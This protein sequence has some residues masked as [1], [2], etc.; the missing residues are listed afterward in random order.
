ME[1]QGR[2][3]VSGYFRPHTLIPRANEA[4]PL[5][6]KSFVWPETEFALI[7]PDKKNN[8]MV[9]IFHGLS[10]RS[11]V[12]FAVVFQPGSGEETEQLIYHVSAKLMSSTEC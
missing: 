8:L 3:L 10:A 5:I 12:H 9:T 2:C 1:S 4:V 7:H 6:V 11:L